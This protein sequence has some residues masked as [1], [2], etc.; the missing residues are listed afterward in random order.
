M[1]GLDTN[2]L[3]RHLVGDDAKQ[4]ALASRFL[5]SRC[6]PTEPGYVNLVVLCELAWTLDRTYGYARSD[7]ARVIDNLLMA[8]ELSV[9]RPDVVATALHRY[10]HGKIGFSDAL[11][12]VLNQTAGCSATATFDGKAARIDGFMPVS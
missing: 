8:R 12:C 2:L 11:I 4:A 9:E 7:I 10:R 1:I 5:E 6:S 3:V